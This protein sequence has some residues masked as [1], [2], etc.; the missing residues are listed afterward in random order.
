MRRTRTWRGTWCSPITAS[1]ASRSATRVISPSWRRGVRAQ[2]ARAGAGLDRDIPPMLGQPAATLTVDLEPVQPGRRALMDPYR[3]GLRDRYG[4]FVLAYL[5]AVVRIA[6]WRASAGAEA[7]SDGGGPMR[8]ARSSARPSG[9]PAR[10]AGKLS[11]RPGPDPGARRAGRPG[12]DRRLDAGR[13]GHRHDGAGH[14][15]LA[16]RGVVPTPVLSPWNN[17]SGFGAKDKE[18]LRAL[19]ALLA[20]PSPR[21]APFRSTPSA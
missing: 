8:A 15:R 7:P 12:G 5:E 14:R 6:D 2:A 21:L 16:S 13:A 4:P 17:G 20:H 10:A 1:C 19:E 3:P 9:P 18:P 11:G